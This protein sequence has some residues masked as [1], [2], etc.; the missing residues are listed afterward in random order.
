M[1][2]EGLLLPRRQTWRYHAGIEVEYVDEDMSRDSLDDIGIGGAAIRSERAVTLGSRLALRLK[3][4]A[5]AAIEVTGEVCWRR[6]G[7]SPAFG[8]HFLFSCPAERERVKDLIGRIQSV[9][10][11]SRAGAGH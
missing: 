2:G 1:E 8:V 3:A 5:R 9:M 10:A 6:P 11:E 7:S 4:P